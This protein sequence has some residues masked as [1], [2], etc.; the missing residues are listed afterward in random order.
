METRLLMVGVPDSE[1]AEPFV[2]KMADR[3][4]MSYFKYG[5]VSE[6]YPIKVD[7]LASLKLRLA[8]YEETGNK[9]HLIDAANYAMIEFMHPRHPQ[10][11]FVAED[12]K[13]SPGRVWGTG[14]ATQDAN[15]HARENVRLGGSQGFTSG[16]HYKRE[17]D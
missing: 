10:A 15:S 7:A 8:L 1:F 9:E 3:M 12:S 16:G 13:A 4:S 2:Q 17:G 5:L 6:A 11:H 14:I